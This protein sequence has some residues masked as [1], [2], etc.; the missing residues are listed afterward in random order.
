MREVRP[1]S[2]KH[3]SLMQCQCAHL[4]NN[5]QVQTHPFFPFFWSYGHRFALPATTSNICS[6]KKLA[7]P[8]NWQ[9][10]PE[11]Y[12]IINDCNIEIKYA[13][14]VL[15]VQQLNKRKSFFYH[16]NGYVDSHVKTKHQI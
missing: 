14:A 4:Y 15:C 5:Q 1:H 7:M 8:L 10:N 2:L 9:A 11:L 16:T 3:T 12:V 6:N 13:L